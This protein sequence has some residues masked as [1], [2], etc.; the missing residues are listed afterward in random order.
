MAGLRTGSRV[1]PYRIVGEVG[2]GGMG[3][4]Y[5]ARD[6]RLGRDVAVKVLAANLARSVDA[7]RR[8]ELEARAASALDHPNVM[9]I[10]DVGTYHGV[11]YQVCEL[12]G[13]SRLFLPSFSRVNSRPEPACL[14]SFFAI[15]HHLYLKADVVG[16]E[17]RR[18]VSVVGKHS[19]CSQFYCKFAVRIETYEVI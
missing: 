15:C 18:Q 8:F 9:T 1:G 5:R 6:T 16:N 3:V 14:G 19:F 13:K 7:V 12:L 17:W 4:V 2:A 10:Y 11:P